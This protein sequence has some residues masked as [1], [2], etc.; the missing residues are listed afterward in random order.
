MTTKLEHFRAISFS[1]ATLASLATFATAYGAGEIIVER[2]LQVERWYA[3]LGSVSRKEFGELI[4]DDATIV[5]KDQGIEQT[6][7]EF[8]G[9]LRKWRRATRK[10][11]IIYRYET[12]EDNTASVSVCYRYKSNELLN[13]ESFTFEGEY[14]TGSVQEPKGDDCGDM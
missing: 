9:A 4:A 5:L 6:K 2:P 1:I 3:A 7:D 13:L 11:N 10:A 12:I 14:I 8:I